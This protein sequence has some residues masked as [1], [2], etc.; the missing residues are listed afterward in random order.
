MGVTIHFDGELLDEDAFRS[1]VST[2]SAFA[3]RQTWLTEP[4]ESDQTTL[5]RV[6]DNEEEW[7]YIGPVKGIVLYPGEDCDPVRLE[8]DED[9]YVQEYTKT[10]FAGVD[11]HI[12]V[13]ELLKSLTPF[14][15]KLRV[16]DEGEYWETADVRTLTEHMRTVQEIIESEVKK[17]P[18]AQAKVKT[19]NGRIMDLMS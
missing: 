10:Q 3:N 16:Q 1:L 13:V 11:T 5:L 19:P 14:F 9:L 7:D 17:D 18:S 6:R 4:I 12:K 2:A 8:F 15:R